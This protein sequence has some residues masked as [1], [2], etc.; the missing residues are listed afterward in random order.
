MTAFDEAFQ[1]LKQNF[2]ISNLPPH[3]RARNLPDMS[4]QRFI[5]EGLHRVG[6]KNCWPCSVLLPPQCSFAPFLR[7]SSTCC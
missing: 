7:A 6:A 3:I 1:M 4:P 2:R 5:D